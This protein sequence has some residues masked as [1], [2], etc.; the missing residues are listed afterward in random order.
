MKSKPVKVTLTNEMYAELVERAGSVPLSIYVR[1]AL[2]EKLERERLRDQTGRE[3][4]E[5]T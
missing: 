5:V 4:W 3:P 2:A 1:Q